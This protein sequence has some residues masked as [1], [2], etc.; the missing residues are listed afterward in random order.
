MNFPWALCIAL[1]DAAALAA[2]R[3]HPGLEVATGTREVWLRGQPADERFSARLLA[4]PATGRFEWLLPDKLRPLEN[5]IPSQRLPVLGWQRLDAWLQVEFPAAALPANQPEAVTLR[6][7][8]SGEERNP[9]LLLTRLDVFQEF[10]AQAALVRLE[11]LRFAATADGHVL[12]H[13]TPLPPLPGQRFVLHKGL[14]VPAG[15]AWQPAVSAEVLAHRLG[16]SDEAPVLWNEDGTITRLHSE[17]FV[18]ATRSAV[19]TTVK[20]VRQIA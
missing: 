18:S 15:Y 16:A 13:G 14:A 1:E 19:L 6:L 5:R 12:I 10:A 4:L 11:R 3:L 2:L 17:Q 20:A 9:D 8:R 7:V